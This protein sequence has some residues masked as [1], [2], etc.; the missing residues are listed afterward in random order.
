[1]S[2]SENAIPAAKIVGDLPA[3]EVK[4]SGELPAGV[5]VVPTYKLFTPN[6][7]MAATFFGGPLGGAALLALNERRLGN[8][9]RA[10]VLLA[11]GVGLTFALI[12]A[13]LAFH[14]PA[15]LGGLISIV[16][17]F[18]MQAVARALHDKVLN[19][20]LTA[21]G[22]FGSGW[23]P[24]GLGVAG[25]AISLG[26]L[27]VFLLATGY[28]GLGIPKLT[29]TPGHD[30]YYRDGATEGQARSLGKLLDTQG[31]FA[32][33]TQASVGL[34]QHGVVHVVEFVVQDRAFVDTGIQKVFRGIGDIVSHEVF[35]GEPVE[36]WLDD[37]H[38]EPK[39][40]MAPTPR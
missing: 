4:G 26:G 22:K 12:Y 17:I 35:D 30:V 7:V 2:E 32:Q 40:K 11:A 29:I 10:R 13:A 20:H 21:G 5:S 19:A 16:N 39:L 27:F 31:F 24:F 1:M 23:A 38:F 14:L 9:A 18:V 6:H 37:N 34:R 28:G 25:L 8:A 3:L 15:S 33:S 36:V